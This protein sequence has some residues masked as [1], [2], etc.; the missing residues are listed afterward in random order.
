[1]A[2][3]ADDYFTPLGELRKGALWPRLDGESEADRDSRAEDDVTAWISQAYARTSDDETSRLYVYGKA[4]RQMA[5]TLNA[6]PA[7]AANDEGSRSYLLQQ[8]EY[9]SAK[10]DAALE[11][12]DG[13]TVE[14]A[15]E[16]GVI[17][18]LR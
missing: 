7:T 17:T 3:S 4:W 13:E 10:A 5:D 11:E 12:F 8:I 15:G 18:S 2:L 14:D 6:I 9:W 16:F 1:M